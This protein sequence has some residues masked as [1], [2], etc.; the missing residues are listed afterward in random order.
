MAWAEKDWEHLAQE[1][2]FVALHSRQKMQS[3]GQYRWY[4]KSQCFGIVEW[5]LWDHLDPVT[6]TWTEKIV[7]GDTTQW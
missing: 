4:I 5:N 1:L 6:W 3:S 7:K 2:L